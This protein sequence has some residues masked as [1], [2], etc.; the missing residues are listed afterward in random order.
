MTPEGAPLELVELASLLAM[1]GARHQ[2]IHHDYRRF[3]DRAPPCRSDHH[4][5][6]GDRD[7]EGRVGKGGS[8]DVDGGGGS[9]VVGGVGVLEA[10]E[11]TLAR[12]GKMPPRLVTFV[13]LQDVPTHR[14]GPTVFLRGTH[15]AAAHDRFAGKTTT[16]TSS[17]STTSSTRIS[18]TTSRKTNSTSKPSSTKRRWENKKKEK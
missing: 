15:T 10:A 11:D 6:H 9:S 13:Y 16:P 18:T 7:K 3:R 8:G 5:D 4:D 14:H 12:L 1:P 2:Q 17:T